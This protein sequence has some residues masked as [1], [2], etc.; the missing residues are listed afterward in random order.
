MRFKRSYFYAALL[1]LTFVVGLASGFLIWGRTDS[2]EAGSPGVTSLPIAPTPVEQQPVRLEV[3]LDDDPALGPD[4]A[5]IVIVEFS[6]FNCPFCQRFH[7]ETFT[8]LMDAYAGQIKFVY[9]DF[10][11]VGGGQVGFEAARAANCAAEQGDYW[12]FHDALFSGRYNLDRNGFVQYA[13]GL[14]MDQTLLEECLDSGRYD[15]EVQ[16]DFREGVELGVTGTPTFFINGIPLVGAQPLS[17]FVRVIE[18]ELAPD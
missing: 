6:D 8:D 9:R 7:Q 18:P 10:P 13:S 15:D 1:P 2:P 4:D 14:G 12:A 11:I 5:Q 16:A 17:S 3:S